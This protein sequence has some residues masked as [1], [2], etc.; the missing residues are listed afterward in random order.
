MCSRYHLLNDIFTN[1]LYFFQSNQNLS[2][3][4][5]SSLAA[6][7]KN[8]YLKS[9]SNKKAVDGVTTCRLNSKESMKNASSPRKIDHQMQQRAFNRQTSNLSNSVPLPPITKNEDGPVDLDPPA[10]SPV[11][12]NNLEFCSIRHIFNPAPLPIN[13]V[14]PHSSESLRTGARSKIYP[15]VKVQDVRYDH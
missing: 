9:I 15:K 8:H 12:E 3:R 13:I 5:F 7:R 4:T 6:Q 11:Q 1:Y 14:K 10:A 2:K